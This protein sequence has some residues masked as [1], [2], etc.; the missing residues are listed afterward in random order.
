M[1]MSNPISPDETVTGQET[2]PGPKKK[3]ITEE[4]YPDIER[5]AGQGMTKIEIARRLG[6]C[7]DTLREREKENPEI[8][9]TIEI[10]RAT[11][12]DKITAKLYSLALEGNFR[13]IKFFL[14]N[15]APSNWRERPELPLE[16]EPTPPSITVRVID[17]RLK[18]DDREDADTEDSQKVPTTFN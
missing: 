3:E 10:G 18:R 16:D 11:A 7:Y 4:M 5:M 17:G 2:T 9:E 15:V 13:A 14:T 1:N 8:S 12:I 6:M